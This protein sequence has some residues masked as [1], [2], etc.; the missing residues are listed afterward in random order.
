M[1]E[2]NEISLLSGIISVIIYSGLFYLFGFYHGYY[3]RNE[4]L[5]LKIQKLVENR[6]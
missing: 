5:F 1:E 3:Y 4:S 2:T 6:T